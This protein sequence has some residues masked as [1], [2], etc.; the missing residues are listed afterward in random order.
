[1][2]RRDVIKT[3]EYVKIAKIFGKDS[4]RETNDWLHGIF[5]LLYGIAEALDVFDDEDEGEEGEDG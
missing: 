3:L 2:K 1:M 4:A 5:V